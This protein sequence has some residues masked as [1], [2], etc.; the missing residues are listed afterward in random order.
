MKSVTETVTDLALPVVSALGLELW[1]VEFLKEGS[2][3]VLRIF[4][5][6]QGGVFIDDCEAVSKAIDPLLDDADPIDK[7]YT[8]E[9]SSAGVER[10]LKRDTDFQRYIGS[11]V[12]IRLYKAEDGQKEH[13]GLLTAFDA[14]TLTL[15]S[16]KVFERKNISLARLKFIF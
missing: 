3:W 7:A 15:D 12:Q 13:T 9:V 2:D 10:V 8:L 4:I 16:I 1:D 11:N 5:D 14:Q 6:K